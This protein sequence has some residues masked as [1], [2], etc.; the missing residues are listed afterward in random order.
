MRADPK[1][2]RCRLKQSITISDRGADMH[3]MRH[4]Q[5]VPSSPAVVQ[6]PPSHRQPRSHQILPQCT[7][8]VAALI[9][10]YETYLKTTD[11]TVSEG[12][13]WSRPPLPHNVPR[14]IS[15]KRKISS[16]DDLVAMERRHKTVRRYPDQSSECLPWW[17]MSAADR[18]PRRLRC[19]NCGDSY[20]DCWSDSSRRCT[21]HP[22]EPEVGCRL[23]SL[24]I[25]PVQDLTH[26]HWSCCRGLLGSKGC[27]TTRHRE[28]DLS[29]LG[30]AGT[31]DVYSRLGI[32]NYA[33]AKFGGF[34]VVDEKLES[35]MVRTMVEVCG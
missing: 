23:G 15:A 6:S 29:T 5:Q 30:T 34:D 17:S 24:Y 18:P 3:C 19:V 8:S 9:A 4:A 27:L 31:S 13:E 14:N 16:D 10:G 22:G 32:T 25:Y 20:D 21:Y 2:H 7:T 28:V 1:T 35:S 33:R 12:M 26:K 11:T